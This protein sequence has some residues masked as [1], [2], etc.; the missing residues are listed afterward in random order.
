M[1]P[2]NSSAY[3]FGGLKKLVEFK[4]LEFPIKLDRISIHYEDYDNLEGGSLRIKFDA[5]RKEEIRIWTSASGWFEYNTANG[6]PKTVFCSDEVNG[7]T[8]N[9]SFFEE[10]ASQFGIDYKEFL[11]TMNAMLIAYAL[12]NEKG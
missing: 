2:R 1:N 6:K 8:L 7:I 3:C 4:D 5:A 11:E 10:L 9:K 12:S